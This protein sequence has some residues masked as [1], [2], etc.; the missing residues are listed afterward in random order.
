MTIMLV[1]LKWRHYL[2]ARRFLIKTDQESLKFL[3]EHNDIRPEYQRWISK[4]MG[5]TFDIIYH[6]GRS[7][8][9]VDSLSRQE[10]PRSEFGG[11]TTTCQ[12]PWD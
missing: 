6:A 10:F 4:I 5:F 12:V 9:V 1:V 7:N 3:M 8:I 2:L 11:L